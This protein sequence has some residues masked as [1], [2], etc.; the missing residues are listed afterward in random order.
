MSEKLV[1]LADR[2]L[3]KKLKWSEGDIMVPEKYA[4][5]ADRGRVVAV[6]PGRK[7]APM[8]LKPGDKV[9]FDTRAQGQLVKIDGEDY[10]ILY[11]GEIAGKLE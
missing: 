8:M 1:P 4:E 10:L 7:D 2:V 3:C 5:Q 6:G 11:E 9:V